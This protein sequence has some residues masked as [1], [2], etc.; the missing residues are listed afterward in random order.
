MTYKK[1]RPVDFGVLH[2]RLPLGAVVSIL[3]RATGLV[4]VLLLPFG[5]YVLDR[6]LAS[7]GEFAH[8]QQR[9]TGTGWRIA[10]VVLAWIF[11]HHF[12]AG[13]RHLLQDVDIGID[14]A[15]G[16]RGAMWVLVA[17]FAS[18]GAV[19]WWVFYG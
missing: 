3:H 19:A 1:N 17:G 14:R 18:A 10:A 12:F 6:S 13:L 16:R 7:A 8:W 11:A 9:F 4:L 5:F 2:S 15:S